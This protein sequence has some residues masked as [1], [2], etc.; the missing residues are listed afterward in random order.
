MQRVPTPCT[1]TGLAATLALLKNK[2]DLDATKQIQWAGRTN[3]KS[4]NAL[5]GILGDVYKGE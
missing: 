2:G 3:D 4:K 1:H 5:Q